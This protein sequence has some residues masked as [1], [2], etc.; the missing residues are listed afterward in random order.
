MTPQLIRPQYLKRIG[1]RI[2]VAIENMLT[3]IV[4]KGTLQ[5][6][7]FVGWVDVRKPNKGNTR[8]ATLHNIS[9]VG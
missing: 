3:R 4:E 1:K 9:R 6:M 2:M 5:C 7:K 8:F